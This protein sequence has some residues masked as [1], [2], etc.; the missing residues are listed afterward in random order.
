MKYFQLH[1]TDDQIF[2]FPS[3]KFPQLK[4]AYTLAEVKELVRFADERGVTMVPEFEVPGHSGKLRDAFPEVFG[5]CM[6]VI[7]FVRDGGLP[8]LDTLVG[9][10][11][12]VFRSSPYFHIGADECNMQYFET[13]PTVI[14]HRKRTGMN[15]PQQFTWFINEMN[16]IVKKHG[17]KTIC[18]EG[19]NDTHVDKDVI[20]IA[21][22]GRYFSPPE[23][24]KAGHRII[25]VPWDPSVHFPARYNYDWNMWLVGSQLRR[26]D[27]LPRA[28][29][30]EKDPVIGGQMVLWEMAGELSL[31]ILRGKAP[32]RHERVHS[33]DAGK[34]YA[35]YDRRFASTNRILDL[36]VH[37]FAVGTE[38]L[39]DHGDSTFDRPFSLTIT[40]SP[41][42]KDAVIYYT[43]DGTDPT[44][45]AKAYT[46]PI[47]LAEPL[48]GFRAQ[49]FGADGKPIGFLRR[50]DYRFNPISGTAETLLPRDPAAPWCDFFDDPVMVTL[51]SG[52]PGTIRYTVD[53]KPATA[54][55]PAYTQPVRIEKQTSINAALF[56]DGKA[57]GNPW[58]G[59]YYWV[60]RG[61]FPYR[62][63]Q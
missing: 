41:A 11:C 14:E 15:T 55:S 19:F 40:P 50:T 12:D 1:L 59:I 16:K 4:G 22:D 44:P 28:E 43:L 8:I 31:P 6:E 53:G 51:K 48:T 46:G 29:S 57:V 56:V 26:P 33:P 36:L 23:L 3:T 25:N 49:A 30:P 20:V 45:K 7:N 54:E 37:G 38:G 52:A 21:W 32:A 2:A 13:L 10:M 62:S 17:K 61:K 5:G 39:T 34:T 9:E 42:L 24:V 27:Q 35:D 18:W 60:E 63:R 47:V 58:L